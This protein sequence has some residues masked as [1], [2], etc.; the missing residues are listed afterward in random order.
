MD[1]NGIK[2]LKIKMFQTLAD[3]NHHL[4]ICKLISA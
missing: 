1:L 3:I 4:Y 2:E